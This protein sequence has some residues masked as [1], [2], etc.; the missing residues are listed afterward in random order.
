MTFAAPSLPSPGLRILAAVADAAVLRT[1]ERTCSGEDL[2]FFFATDVAEALAAGTAEQPDV[3]FVDV[4]LD[5]GA[6][7]ALVHHLPAV[8]SHSS[9]Y[10]IIPGRRMELG[11]QAMALGAAGILVAPPSGD[12]LLLAISEVR[13]R[14]AAAAER[15]RMLA[16]LTTVKRRTEL[17]ETV[18]ALAAESDPAK[19]ALRIA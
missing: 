9:V 11:S 14:R 19:A 1:I 16:E 13:T 17:L 3:A 12:G 4:T 15:A 6:G 8:S 5:G 10:A 7:L 2:S 18:A